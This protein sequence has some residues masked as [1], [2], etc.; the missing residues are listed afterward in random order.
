MLFRTN[1]RDFFTGINLTLKT[2]K[3]VNKQKL[4]SSLDG[5][6]E[7]TTEERR[8]QMSGLHSNHAPPY[9]DYSNHFLF[10]CISIFYFTFQFQRANDF[11]P[12]LCDFP[13]IS[14]H[15]IMNLLFLFT[16]F[17]T[18]RAFTIHASRKEI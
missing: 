7:I 3:P 12:F 13:L 1:F 6:Y 14:V 17:H 2:K 9:F 8:K 4:H 18:T 16:T 15:R 5:Y 10:N 11:I